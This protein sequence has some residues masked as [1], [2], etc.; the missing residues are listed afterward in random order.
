MTGTRVGRSERVTGDEPGSCRNIT[1]DDYIGKEQYG[2]FCAAT[3]EPGD[4]KVGVSSTQKGSAVSGTLT[5]RS[6]KVTGDEPGTCKAITGTPYAGAEQYRSYC[7]PEQAQQAAA[8]TP[9]RN[10]TPGSVM[11]GLQPGIGGTLTGAEKGACENV[12]G[13]PYVGADQFA[14]ACPATPADARQS[15]FSAAAGRDALGWVQRH[16]A[17]PGRADRGAHR[18]RHRLDL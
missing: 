13:T 11:T 4:Y 6:G 8:R 18:C 5:G 12:S 3:P 2:T 9:A 17:F 14:A 15:R 1:G 10:A 7:A 16:I